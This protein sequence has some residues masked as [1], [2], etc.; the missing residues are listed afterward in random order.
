MKNT[1]AVILNGEVVQENQALISPFNRGMMYGDGCFETIR[2]YSG[3]FLGWDMRFERLKGGLDYLNIDAPFTSQELKEQVL[4]LLSKN[5]LSKADAMIRLQCWRKG[6][7]GYTPSSSE[8]NWMI[9]AS[10]L[11]KHHNA[12]N[13]ILAETRCIPSVALERKYKLSN[14]LNYIKAAQEAKEKSGDDSLMLTVNGKISET[15]S[16]NIFWVKGDKVF[17]PSVECYLLPGVTRSIV[18]NVI[19]SLGIQIEE[20]V[21]DLGAIEE[22]EAV[23]CTNSLKEISEV[24]SLDEHRFEVS[25]PLV[26]KIKTGFNRFKEQEL[27]A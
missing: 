21:F 2:S 8:A 12:I 1:D 7:R 15:T 26:Q 17:T 23:F 13:L 4:S 18:I 5:S 14:G 25:H 27:E 19:Q 9:Q 11:S 22:A 10:A 16:A 20:G 24:Q 6:G 3:K